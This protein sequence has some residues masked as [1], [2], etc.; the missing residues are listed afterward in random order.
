[1]AS[2][3]RDSSGQEMESVP[4]SAIETPADP[5]TVNSEALLVKPK[6]SLQ[7]VRL[8]AGACVCVYL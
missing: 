1:M 5:A 4:M 6:I 8:Y 2:G 3:T 7:Q